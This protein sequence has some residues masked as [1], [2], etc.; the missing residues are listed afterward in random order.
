MNACIFHF[1]L[2]AESENSIFVKLA[3][4]FRVTGRLLV[5]TW[6]LLQRF[7]EVG[8]LGL[9][10]FSSIHAMRTRLKGRNRRANID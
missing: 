6:G 2:W 8:R 7:V 10:Q 4:H 1:P 3:A 5:M 9:V